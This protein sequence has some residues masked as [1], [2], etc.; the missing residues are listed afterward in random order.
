VAG[1]RPLAVACA[2]ARLAIVHGRAVPAADCPRP[3]GGAGVDA[4]DDWA[5]IWYGGDHRAFVRPDAPAVRQHRRRSI[6]RMREVLI[7]AAL[8]AG[9]VEGASDG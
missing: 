5:A 2:L 7:A 6:D 9:V 1:R 4:A 8:R 3:E